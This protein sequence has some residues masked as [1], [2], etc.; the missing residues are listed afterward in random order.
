MEEKPGAVRALRLEKL[1]TAI[2]IGLITFVAGL[3]ILVVLSMTSRTKRATLPLLMSMGARRKQIRTVFFMA[4]N[5]HRNDRYARWSGDRLCFFVHRGEL[6]LIP[7]DP[8]VYAVPYVPFHPAFWTDCGLRW[9]R[10]ES[11]S[12]RPSFPRELRRG[13]CRWRSSV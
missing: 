12:L 6:S 10:W 8:Q 7:L 4:G 2:F 9:W 5:H 1:V 11:R 13:C 3:N